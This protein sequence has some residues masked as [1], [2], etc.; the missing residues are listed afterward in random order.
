MNAL[1]KAGVIAVGGF[2]IVGAYVGY[3]VYKAVTGAIHAIEAPFQASSNAAQTVWNARPK[4][5]FKGID[6]D[7]IEVL[8]GLIK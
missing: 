6:D 3:K 4:I 5:I 2:V 1:E 7:E 8:G